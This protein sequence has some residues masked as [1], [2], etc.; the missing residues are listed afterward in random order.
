VAAAEA[1]FPA[2]KKT[3]P[4]KKR[5]YMLRLA[6][7]MIE[8]AK[9]L[10]TLTRITMGMPSAGFGTLEVGVAAEAVKYYAGWA[11]K[12][13]GQS[14]AAEDGFMK[15]THNEPLGVVVGVV[16]FNGPLAILSH[17]IGPALITGNCFIVKPSEKTPFAALALGQLAKEA[18][19]PAGVFQ[20][21]TGDGSTGALLASHM[22]VRGIS[23]TGSGP[24]GRKVQEAAAK[25]NFKRVVL[26]L[27]GKGPALVFD[28][29][30][31]DVTVAWCVSGITM[32]TGQA[33]VAASRVYVQEGVYPKFL[34]A[35]KKALEAK[36]IGDP[37]LSTTEMGP[38]VD[39]AQF[40]TASA[41]IE[42][43]KSQ[44]KLLTGG[45]N[46]SDKVS[47]ISNFLRLDFFFIAGFRFRSPELQ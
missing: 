13:P 23:F 42:R 47:H 18:G 44:G 11:D 39:K 5:D 31:I 21:L 22:R 43:A 10:A 19:F 12:F 45:T 7:L 3:L 32:N 34:E 35:Y 26:E 6:D 36:V 8:H 25:S 37:D 17:K 9:T 33:C 30:N 14:H 29:C 20:V 38:I 1:A 2:W 4:R 41:Y 27:G 24:T 15:I 28:D 16:P 40:D 46:V